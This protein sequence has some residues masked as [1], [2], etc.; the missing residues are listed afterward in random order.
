M[1]RGGARRMADITER[2]SG[3]SFEA[4]LG[5]RF[6]VFPQ[7][8]YVPGYERPEVVWLSVPAGQVRAGPQDSR[9]YVAAPV[10]PKAPYRFPDLPP[11]RGRCLPPVEPGSGGHF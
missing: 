6:L 4:R 11:V 2:D 3:A 9:M 1:R 8:P 7:P 5:T 10:A